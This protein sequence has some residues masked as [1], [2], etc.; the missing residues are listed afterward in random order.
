MNTT[1][2]NTQAPGAQPLFLLQDGTTVNFDTDEVDGQMAM[3]DRKLAGAVVTIF[4]GPINPSA[5]GLV[6]VE[7]NST[8]YRLTPYPVNGRDVWILGIKVSGSLLDRGRSYGVRVEGFTAPDGTLMRPANFTVAT[9]PRTSASIDSETNDYLAQRIAEE[10]IVLLK[11]RGNVLPVRHQQLNILGSG[12]AKFRVTVVGAGKT[13]ARHTVRLREAIEEHGRFSLNTELADFHREHGDSIPP[14]D[15]L[16]RAKSSGDL[17]IVVLSRL[18][19]ENM[20][21]SSDPGAYNLSDGEK[22]LLSIASE[23]FSRTIVILNT[24][25]PID[26]RFV[27]ELGIDAV[28]LTGIG[29]MLAGPAVVNVLDGTVNP[30]G[31]LT[32]TWP[33]KLSDI[34][35][36]QNFYDAVGGGTPYT[37][38]SDVWIDTVYEEG[39]YVGYRYF[40][41]FGTEVVYPFGYGLSYT[42]FRTRAVAVGTDDDIAV[43]CEV[44]NTGDC[45][46]R[47]VVQLY[48]TKPDGII[49]QPALELLD[50]AKTPLLSP[51]STVTM[52][53]VVPRR[54]LFTYDE[55]VGRYVLV[56]GEYVLRLGGSVE[57]A[58][59]IG[60]FA[61]EYSIASDVV[62]HRLLPQ[63]AI[64]TLSRRDPRGTWPPGADSGV[65]TEKNAFLP[66]RTTWHVTQPQ[67]ACLD[68]GNENLSFADVQE[69]P[70]LVAA[71]VESLSIDQ[72]ARLTV[73]A[74]PAWGMEGTG[75][76]GVLARP[77]GLDLP[78]FQVADGNSG[79]NVK[80][81]NIGFPT[82][83][84]LASTF[85]KDLAYDMG[86]VLGEEA[87]KLD[88]DVILAPALNL[89]RHPLNGRHPEYFSEDPYLSGVLAGHYARG[90]ESTGVGACYKHFA[91][92]NTETARK[93]NQSVVP[94]R[95]LR[96][97]YLKAFEVALSVHQPKTVMTAYNAIN[98]CATSTDAELLEGVL[99]RD[100]QFEG[101]LMTDW[102]SYASAD[103][104][105]MVAGGNNWITPGSA[106]DEFTAPIV[107][108]VQEGRLSER[109]LRQSVSYLLR[110]I[111]E[112]TA[113]SSS[114]TPDVSPAG[115]H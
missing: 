40:S 81:P 86:R 29:G 114:T 4:S 24:P 44:S 87:R 88:I 55:A 69:C 71:Y 107:A 2:R 110:V 112:L 108:A 16:A 1:T 97:L 85:D 60:R 13:N 58:I 51:G 53:L 78:T 15:M 75:V 105:D 49:E 65:K 38:D 67:K 39:I 9:K 109:R 111:A 36:S 91:A 14:D 54:Q 66:A 94:E 23:T 48:V 101:M 31:R 33:K 22:R 77:E 52:E 50:F 41:T 79:V 98:G 72:L 59:E 12:L 92:N 62:S 26:V 21:N 80:T 99:R 95:A 73:C 115:R 57:E 34:P 32:D 3:I 43:Q 96:D 102:G 5:P 74:Q 56:P 106:D 6:T 45:A 70:E 93:R 76:A 84:V 100:F 19:G 30:S 82:T 64:A 61:V 42:T 20:D 10:G 8:S 37:G 103:V 89:H 63:Q 104:V 27:D 46:G 11:N 17:G 28:I 18:S 68:G 35:A 47:E 83:V 113:G 25:Y 7:G 90:L